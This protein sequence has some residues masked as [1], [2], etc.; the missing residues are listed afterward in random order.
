MFAQGAQPFAQQGAGQ[1]G[2]QLGN[3]LGA[4]VQATLP[5]ILGQLRGQQS[6]FGANQIGAPGFNSQS[7]YG[8]Q[9]Y[10][11]SD[12]ANLVGPVLQATLPVILNSL[13]GQQG[14]QGQQGQG[15]Q[16]WYGGQGFGQGG[17]PA[18]QSLGQYGQHGGQGDLG[19]VLGPVLQATLPA[20]LGSLRGQQQGFGQQGF[21]QLGIPAFQSQGQHG[22]QGDLSNI[23]GPVLQATLPVVLASLQSQQAQGAGM[24][25]RN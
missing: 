21:G 3:A 6:G 25:W 20:I 2:A 22:G 16:G 8:A 24:G 5:A 1:F 14:Q 10:G 7:P 13:R 9:Q 11:Q 17:M 18:F 23:L 19:N 15:Q 12:A 4:I